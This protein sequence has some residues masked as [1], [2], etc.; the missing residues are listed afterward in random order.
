MLT[1]TRKF[2]FDAG[3]RI[4][5][6]KSLCKNL[7][8]H[9]YQLEITLKGSIIENDGCSE[10]GMLM[11]FSDIKLI[12]KKNLIDIWDHS[13]IVYEKDFE[14]KNFLETIKNHR[15]VVVNKI[16]TVEN[17]AKF[18]FEILKPLFRSRYGNNLKLHRLKLNETPNCWAEINESEF[19]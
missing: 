9:R 6:H 18:A 10:N 3:H 16:P 13:F 8:G 15:T 17:L 11:D 4:P 12:T 2:E 14:V 19:N 7:H 1:I 5:D